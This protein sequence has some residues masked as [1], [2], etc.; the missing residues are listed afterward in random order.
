[1]IGSICFVLALFIVTTIFVEVNTD[2][3]QDTF[4]M[5][6][7]SSVFVM[8]V[9]SAILSGGLF[10]IAG[11]FPSEYITAVVSGQALGGIFSA[12]AEIVSLTFGASPTSTAFVYF[13]VGNGVL[14]VALLSYI[15]MSKT[16]YFK[17]FTQLKK[18]KSNELIA[19]STSTEPNFR[20][21]F[22][23]IW[24]YGFSEWLVFVTTL[25]I[26]PSVTVLINSQ[27]KGNGHI[28]NDIY[29][30]P[31]VN[32]LIFNTGDYFGRILA[33]MFE[34][35]KNRP[36]LIAF[37]TVL[38]IAFVP[39]LLMCNTNPRHNLPVFIHSDISLI[40][41]MILFSL[42]NGYIANI[43]LIMAPKY[44]HDREKEMA[45]SMMAAFLGIGLAFGSSISLILV[46]IL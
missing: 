42:S 1:M 25:A 13:M 31:V 36:R 43:C 41:M 45:S 39:A 38:R 15:I 27:Y 18:S 14:L 16:V 10:G 33:G 23:K 24:M 19:G 8:N 44:V 9:A 11:Q 37:V 32:Y 21:V 30:V 5:I 3:W 6:T 22:S 28:W 26:Y 46:Q 34:W 7:L 35:P 20:T 12:L 2:A 4:F 40:V 29:F 17:H